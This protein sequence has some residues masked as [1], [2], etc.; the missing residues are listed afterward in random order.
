M[1]APEHRPASAPIKGEDY[2]GALLRAAAQSQ[3]PA[4]K[5]PTLEKDILPAVPKSQTRMQ[6][7]KRMAM[8]APPQSCDGVVTVTQGRP[9]PTPL[10]AVHRLKKDP[11]KQVRDDAIRSYVCHAYRDKKLPPPPGSKQE[12]LDA[13]CKG[14]K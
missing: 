11:R 4:L 7:I 6:G 12:D 5:R 1:L 8:A 13:A 10:T 9:Q 2:M 14:V 3:N